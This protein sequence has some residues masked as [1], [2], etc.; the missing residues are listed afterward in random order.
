MKK[1]NP[2]AMIHKHGDFYK[3]VLDLI[4][5]YKKLF[6]PDAHKR[7]KINIEIA[8]C[9][10]ERGHVYRPGELP[11]LRSADQ[12]VEDFAKDLFAILHITPKDTPYAASFTFSTIVNGD[13][14][15]H[16]SLTYLPDESRP[17]F[18]GGVR[19]L[20][21]LNV[22]AAALADGKSVGHAVICMVNSLNRDLL[23]TQS[24]SANSDAH[25]A[26][27]EVVLREE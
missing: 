13:Y 19:N 17:N 6:D 25:K 21:Y 24:E 27:F 16:L 4:P 10:H 7:S 20:G 15:L 18:L 12:K 9:Y 26:L 3:E 1:F 5:L 11:T 14:G 22:N 2:L 23:A 8:E